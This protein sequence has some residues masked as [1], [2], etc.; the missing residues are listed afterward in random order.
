MPRAEDVVR[1][2]AWV[3][4][5]GIQGEGDHAEESICDRFVERVFPKVVCNTDPLMRLWVA[6]LLKFLF[7][8]GVITELPGVTNE[9]PAVS[10][11]RLWRRLSWW[12]PGAADGTCKVHEAHVDIA[13]LG[14]SR[15]RVRR[16]RAC[17]VC[18]R[19]DWEHEDVF[20][21][22]SELAEN[23]SLVSSGMVSLC[24][25]STSRR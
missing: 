13:A 17:A 20:L 14:G 10:S 4:L 7:A 21:C 25:V 22:G 5:E 1:V 11:S 15:R 12:L 9:V 6:E 2:W 24:D 16:R 19:F 18:A 8:Q 3:L 23:P